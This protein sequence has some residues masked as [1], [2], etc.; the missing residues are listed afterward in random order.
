M[1][2][3]NSEDV[4]EYGGCYAKDTK[5]RKRPNGCFFQKRV[6]VVVVVVVELELQFVLVVVELGLQF[7]LHVV[8]WNCKLLSILCKLS[9]VFFPVSARSFATSLRKLAR[10]SFI[11]TWSAVR[12]EEIRSSDLDMRD[13]VRSSDAWSAVLHSADEDRVQWARVDLAVRRT[14]CVNMNGEM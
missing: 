14:S 7:V 1:Y 2:R 4:A 8:E 12:V 5:N 6:V 9:S 11:S 3:A 10:L 13:Y